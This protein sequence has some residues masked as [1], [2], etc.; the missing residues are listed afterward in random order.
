MFPAL[1]TPAP[2]APQETRHAYAA[3]L[4]TFVLSTSCTS[5]LSDQDLDLAEHA[6]A[7]AVAQ[8]RPDQYQSPSPADLLTLRRLSDVRHHIALILK[9]RRPA[10]AQTP[11]PPAQAP[12]GGAK[13]GRP[14]PLVPPPIVRPPGGA[15]A[16]PDRTPALAGDGIRF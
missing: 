14:A 16:V 3:R 8:V 9:D 10:Q 4:L 15:Y 1:P 6:A 12:T 2:Q 11:R 7:L 5:T 13:P